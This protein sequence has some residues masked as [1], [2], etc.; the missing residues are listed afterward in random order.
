M[1][2][3]ANV[4]PLHNPGLQKVPYPVFCSRTHV[5]DGPIKL[6]SRLNRIRAS[7]EL[8][9]PCHDPSVRLVRRTLD[10]RAFI[11]VLEFRQRAHEQIKELPD[12]E[13]QRW[14]FAG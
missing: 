7:N 2:V 14:L 9:N 5:E 10:L 11:A 12:I 4:E 13:F 3:S 6:A 1:Q 8:G